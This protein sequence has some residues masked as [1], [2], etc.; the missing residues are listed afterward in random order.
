MQ[1]LFL[2]DIDG[3]I[4]RLKQYKSRLIFQKALR[5]LHSIEVPLE[6]IA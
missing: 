5:E 3:T 4:L 1:Y 2:F 6:L